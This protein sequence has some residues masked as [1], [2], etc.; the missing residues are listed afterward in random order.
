MRQNLI[1]YSTDIRM[2]LILSTCNGKDAMNIKKQIFYQQIDLCDLNFFFISKT[3]KTSISLSFKT[4]KRFF[5][6]E[7]SIDSNCRQKR[8]NIQQFMRILFSF[9]LY[10]WTYIGKVISKQFF[11]KLQKHAD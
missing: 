7:I 5:F 8:K 11:I 2:Q 1:S 3:E 6:L 10:H 9:F 4:S